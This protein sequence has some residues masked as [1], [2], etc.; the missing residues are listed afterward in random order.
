MADGIVKY[1]RGRHPNS[2]AALSPQ[3]TQGHSG[4]PKGRPRKQPITG[5]LDRTGN[6]PCPVSIRR[7]LA[8]LGIRLE[9]NAAWNQA[10]SL[11]LYHSAVTRGDVVVAREIT[12]RLEGKARPQ[13]EEEDDEPGTVNVIIQHVGRGDDEHLRRQIP[14]N[15]ASPG[16]KTDFALGCSGLEMGCI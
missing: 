14:G 13:L 6:S 10:L 3:W 15:A 5:E 7:L 11:A 1:E 8:K 12:D 16:L 2:R 9:E 4:N